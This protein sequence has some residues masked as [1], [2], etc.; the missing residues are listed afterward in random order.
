VRALSVLDPARPAAI[1]RNQHEWL[2][3]CDADRFA[4]AF[5]EV[6]VEPGAVFAG[7][8]IVRAPGRA[9]KPFAVGERFESVFH[10]IPFLRDAAE[11]EEIGPG[12]GRYR[13]VEG[14]PLAGA[15]TFEVLPAGPDACRFISL[16]ELQEVGVLGITILHRFGIRAH[17]RV[18][19]AQVA[20]AASRVG[21]SVLGSTVTSD[22][23]YAG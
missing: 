14:G 10:G 7:L 5:A 15:S 2:V 16:F 17:D 18:V 8:R 19:A 3:G 22:T 23:G 4:R 21:A 6:L 9:G 11:I 12:R 1:K 13:Y 20:C